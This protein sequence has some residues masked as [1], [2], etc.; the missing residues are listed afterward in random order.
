[1]I[2]LIT[3][4]PGS[5]KTLYTLK[6][7][8]E[9]AKRE[10]RQVYYYG[11]KLTDYGKEHL[12]WVELED[13]H[14]W[15]ELPKLAIIVIDEFQKVFPKRPNGAQ[16]PKY[17]S[18]FETHRHLGVDVYLITQGT[19]LFDT[20]LKDL[21]GKH[22]HLLRIFGA[23]AAQVLKWDGC[24]Q[25]PNSRTVKA[26]CLDKSKFIY[27]KEVFK[28]YVSAEAHTHKIQIPKKI[29]AFLFFLIVAVVA[30]YFSIKLVGNLG[31]KDA[32]S[33]GAKSAAA[34]PASNAPG[35]QSAQPKRALTV[36]EYAA[37]RVPR[38]TGA[39]E[40]EPRF[41]D[42]A[43]PKTFPRIVACISN[44]K[45]CA[46]YSQQGTQVDLP[47]FMCRERIARSQFDPYIDERQQY[48]PNQMAPVPVSQPIQQQK[49]NPSTYAMG[50]DRVFDRIGES[51]SSDVRK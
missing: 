49:I 25:S 4:T 30:I 46:C 16:V 12:G 19:K 31:K 8:A 27:P 20:H 28:W 7:L 36:A 9:I 34:Q 37:A 33:L 44:A 50:N 29:W 11:I 10:D 17:M 39:P 35:G 14:K 21:I 42:L 41:D 15:Y 2:T 6:T 18:E 24:Q 32:D 13:P 47:D 3:A 51:R 5:G 26:D 1:M 22:I 38:M 43:T 40:S 23:H 48:N 45:K